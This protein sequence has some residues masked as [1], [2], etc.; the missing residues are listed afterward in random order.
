MLCRHVRQQARARSSEQRQALILALLAL[1]ACSP[2]A[3]CALW[4]ADIHLNPSSRAPDP[5]ASLFNRCWT[6]TAASIQGTHTRC[7]NIYMHPRCGCTRKVHTVVLTVQHLQPQPNRETFNCAIDTRPAS[8]VN[9]LQ[10]LEASRKA[11][12][13]PLVAPGREQ[14]GQGGGAGSQ[15]AR[16]KGK[17]RSRPGSRA[18]ADERKR[19]HSAHRPTAQCRLAR[20]AQPPGSPSP[21][22]SSTGR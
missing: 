8:R 9:S 6:G 21:L 16:R 10:R 7:Q 3:V 5:I 17:P 14:A 20:P 18:E 11:N 19:S 12:S 4:D 22:E 15:Q 1:T 13:G 2:C